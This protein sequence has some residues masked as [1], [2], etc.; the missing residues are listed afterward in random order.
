MNKKKYDQKISLSRESF[1]MGASVGMGGPA[2]LIFV[3]Y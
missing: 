3:N 1:R 2:E